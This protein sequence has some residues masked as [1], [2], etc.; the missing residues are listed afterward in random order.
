MASDYYRR[1]Y[2]VNKLYQGETKDGKLT[3]TVYA[4]TKAEAMKE[5]REKGF[6]PVKIHQT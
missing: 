1:H 6:K 3:P 2:G 5:L 4:Y